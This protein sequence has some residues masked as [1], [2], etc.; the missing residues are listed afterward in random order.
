MA[1]VPA[2]PYAFPLA[3]ELSPA[4]TAL[5]VIDMQVDFCGSGGYMDRMGFDLDFLRGPVALIRKVME[6]FRRHGFPI[7][8]TRETFAADLS[9][10]QPHRLWR[11][12]GGIAVGDP[13]PLGRCLIAGE[14]C[15]ELIP[16]LSPLAGEPVFDKAGYGA[17]ARTGLERHLRA[18]GIGNLVIVGLTTDCCVSTSLREALDRGFDCLTLADCCAASTRATHEAA[19]T[20]LRKASGIFGAMANSTAVLDCLANTHEGQTIHA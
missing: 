4:S 9:D 18:A 3:G 12:P 5:L 14:P 6:A 13:G 15:W 1:K 17:F 11:P 10:V 16:E 20:V 7:V 2:E 19:L 8:H